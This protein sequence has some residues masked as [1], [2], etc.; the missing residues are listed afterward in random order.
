MVFTKKLGLL[1]AVILLFVAAIGVSLYI[2]YRFSP[3]VQQ[4]LKTKNV[5]QEVPPVTTS[6]ATTTLFVD[7]GNASV[8]G[9]SLEIPIA[10]DTGGNTV[11]VVEL[12]LS[13]D[14]KLLTG[15][16]IQPGNFFSNPMIIEK[17]IDAAKGTIV[18]VLGS[19]KPR[20]GVGSLVTIT[21]I[22]EQKTSITIHIDPK[23]KVAAIGELGTVL[24][25]TSDGT[26]QVP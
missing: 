3:N 7:A 4:F 22:P 18:F 13:F 23:T 25:S 9:T 14:A 10:I 11:S 17:T 1:F 2:V 8:S 20:Q 12:H 19:L 15:V 6:H 5:S 16:S 26:V 21:A 24:S